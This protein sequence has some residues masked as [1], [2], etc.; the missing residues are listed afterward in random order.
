MLLVDDADA[1]V[2]SLVNRVALQCVRAGELEKN[3]L[4]AENDS[5]V[6]LSVL[7]EHDP[8]LCVVTNLTERPLW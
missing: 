8:G 6:M 3:A 4:A 2:L 7:W 5:V 1:K